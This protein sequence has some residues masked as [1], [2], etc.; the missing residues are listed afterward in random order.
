[1]R[2]LGDNICKDDVIVS[3]GAAGASD[4]TTCSASILWKGSFTVTAVAEPCRR[5]LGV[6]LRRVPRPA[7]A[8]LRMTSLE[9]QLD[10]LDL[11]A[12]IGY[13]EF[14]VRYQSAV[15]TSSFNTG[16][17]PFWLER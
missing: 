10:A 11:L 12:I 3:G 8:G 6:I 14:L 9:D 4:I 13:Q 2:R 16:A 17:G 5:H 7:F 1:M 15:T